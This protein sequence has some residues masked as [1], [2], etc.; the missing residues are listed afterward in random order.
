M[1]VCRSLENLIMSTLLLSRTPNRAWWDI[2]WAHTALFVPPL[3]AN[4]IDLVLPTGTAT[5]LNETDL[6]SPFLSFSMAVSFSESERSE[7]LIALVAILIASSDVSTSSTLI[8]P[9]LAAATFAA[10]SLPLENAASLSTRSCLSLN[11]LILRVSNII[12][13]FLFSVESLLPSACN[14]FIFL[15]DSHN[16]MSFAIRVRLSRRER[17]SIFSP[18]CLLILIIWSMMFC[19]SL[20]ISSMRFLISSGCLAL[21][22]HLSLSSCFSCSNIQP[23]S[24]CLLILKVLSLVIAIS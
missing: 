10:A 4:I 17:L 16:F 22:P 1:Y 18:D 19:C 12:S 14:S 21:G 24:V 11:V 7:S 13:S 8:S 5:P 23:L 9:L 15:L 20:L 3:I 6:E 2:S